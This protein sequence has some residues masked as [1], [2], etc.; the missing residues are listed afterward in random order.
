M[1]EIST[2]TLAAIYPLE[3]RRML[4]NYAAFIQEYPEW[5]EN[6]FSLMDYKHTRTRP[7]FA[8]WTPS[9]KGE[10]GGEDQ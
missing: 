5:V 1:N 3:S 4:R 6:G 7:E 10:N 8:G 2:E 9:V